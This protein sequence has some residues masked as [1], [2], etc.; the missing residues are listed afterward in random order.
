MTQC[1]L[2]NADYTFLN[3][4]NWKRAICLIAKGKV[5]VVRMIILGT[6]NGLIDAPMWG[7]WYMRLTGVAYGW[8]YW[9]NLR[10]I[11]SGRRFNTM[12]V[13]K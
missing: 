7:L 5:E 11:G 6:D 8:R 1:V 4:V 12:G 3:L 13:I 9:E 10:K 2:L